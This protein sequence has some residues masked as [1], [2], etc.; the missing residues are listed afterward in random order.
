M[1]EVDCSAGTYVR[2]L[3]R[4]LGVALGSG[5]YLGALSRTA[6]GPF[7]LADALTVD[8]VR[9]AA[10][11]GPD[12]LAALLKPIDTGLDLRAITL[13]ADELRAVLRGQFFRPSAGSPGGQ[14]D[15]PLR[16]LSA[17]G[18]LVG[19]GRWDGTR[20]MPDKVLADG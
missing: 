12:R 20:I 14:A 15:R 11:E 1:V 9:A 5:A 19:F 16:L 10:G 13:T 17:S 18:E 4:D 8:A 6:S 2:A 7:R 3:A